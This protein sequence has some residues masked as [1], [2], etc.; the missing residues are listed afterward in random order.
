MPEETPHQVSYQRNFDKDCQHNIEMGFGELSR[1]ITDYSIKNGT[2]IITEA[3][4]VGE[5]KSHIIIVIQWCK[6]LY[7]KY[8]EDVSTDKK[9]GIT[10]MKEGY[11][12]LKKFETEIKNSIWIEKPRTIE[13]LDII[14]EHEIKDI[15]VKHKLMDKTTDRQPWEN[16]VKKKFY[17]NEVPPEEWEPHEAYLDTIRVDWKKMNFMESAYMVLKSGDIVKIISG[18]NNS[19][20]T[21]TSLPQAR[22]VNWYL[23]NYWAKQTIRGIKGECLTQDTLNDLAKVKPF[24]MKRDTSFYPDTDLI[25]EKIAEGGRFNTMPITEGMKAA[26]N[27]KSWDAKVIDM[28]IELFTE[29]ASNNYVSFE[30]QL[31]KRPPKM[32]LGRF[33]VWQH[34]PSPQ[35]LVLSM[36]SSVYRSEDPLLSKEIEKLKGD[37]I[38]SKWLTHKSGNVHFIAT[39]KAP[40]LKPKYAEL[41][42]KYR[43]EAKI[44]YEKGKGNDIS[45]G[46]E[47][48][49]QIAKYWED[50]KAGKLAYMSIPELLDAKGYNPK[51]KAKFLR[52]FDKM[53]RIKK[54]SG[55]DD[56]DD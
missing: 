20:K 11:A 21:W 27:L 9:T 14:Q 56:L 52:D 30:Y 22:Q 16:E 45:L 29:R 4:A 36:P 28:I 37:R 24:S 15:A 51:Q 25:R 32:L 48:N 23:R 3:E 7:Y 2:E 33:N 39:M 35:W 8:H 43:R 17:L 46:K 34:K 44:E 19:G 53:D 40:K 5:I 41:F 10:T 47:W 55:G 38:I 18:I 12:A 49:R 26:L 54:L 13:W 31:T 42:K 6:Q 50:V 1:V